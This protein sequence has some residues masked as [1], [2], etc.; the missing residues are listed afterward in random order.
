MLFCL[1]VMVILK[2]CKYC[3]RIHDSKYN[4]GKQPVRKKHGNNK[5]K[6]RWTKVWQSKREEIKQRDL[7]L[8]QICIRNL[9]DTRNRYERDTLEVHHAISLEQDFDKRL[10][11][12]NLITLCAR[13]HEMSE[14]NE[15]PLK[16]I[17]DII[18]EQNRD[19]HPPEGV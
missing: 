18:L 10:D 1:V 6:F 12:D 3:C 19:M 2:S 16:T 13:H 15:I 17:L 9:F 5:D 8:C 7:Y 14:R 4:C 11:N